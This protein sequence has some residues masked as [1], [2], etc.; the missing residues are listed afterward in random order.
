M[1]PAITKAGRRVALLV[2]HN[3]QVVETLRRLCDIWPDV[4]T[5][6]MHSSSSLPSMPDW[7]QA[8]NARPANLQPAKRNSLG[9]QQLRDGA[10][11]S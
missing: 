1:A 8:R 5:T 6:F 7:I 11:C 3:D 2:A 4:T 10:A 9:W